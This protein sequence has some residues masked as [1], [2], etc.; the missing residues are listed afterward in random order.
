MAGFQ[1]FGAFGRWPWQ[2]HSHFSADCPIHDEMLAV[3]WPLFSTV[4]SICRPLAF[5]WPVFSTLEVLVLKLQTLAFSWPLFSPNQKWSWSF[6]GRFSALIKSGHE[7]SKAGSF[8]ATFDRGRKVAM[9]LQ[10]SAGWRNWPWNCQ[11]PQFHGNCQGRQFE[12]QSS[13]CAEN[14]PRNCQVRQFENMPLIMNWANGW[15]AA[16]KLPRSAVWELGCETACLSPWKKNVVQTAKVSSSMATFST[17]L[18]WQ[19]YP[20]VHI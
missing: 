6:H 12:N 10:R 19:V 14:Q 8:M 4:I 18:I 11:G 3:S 16:V 5:S 15:K 1:H 7:T 13:Q 9:N 20:S 2:F 17:L